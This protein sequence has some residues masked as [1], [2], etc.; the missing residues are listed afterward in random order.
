MARHVSQSEV[1]LEEIRK[2]IELD[3]KEDYIL[4]MVDDVFKK[5]REKNLP[6]D[7]CH[8]FPDG[9]TLAGIAEKKKL[10]KIESLFLEKG[11]DISKPDTNSS[12]VLKKR[13]VTTYDGKTA[14]VAK[15]THS[16]A[17][18]TSSA[19]QNE[20]TGLKSFLHGI[21]YQLKLILII[22][23]HAYELKK[24]KSNFECTVS[25]EDP[26]AGKFDDIV[27]KYRYP[28]EFNTVYIQAKHKKNPYSIVKNDLTTSSNDSPFALVP[29]FS[30]FLDLKLLNNSNTKDLFLTTNA[31]IDDTLLPMVKE[32]KRSTAAEIDTFLATISDSERGQQSTCYR[33]NWQKM[34]LDG[35]FDS[36]KE[37][38]KNCSNSNRL[39]KLLA[40]HIHGQKK[41]TQRT[42]LFK[43]NGAAII[44]DIV[45][46][47]KDKKLDK[48]YINDNFLTLNPQ[49]RQN[50]KYFRDIFEAEYKKLAKGTDVWK[51][52]KS[53]GISVTS[54]FMTDL[55]PTSNP[56]YLPNDEVTD[57]I[58]E[59]FFNVFV[60]VCNTVNEEVLTKKVVE[61]WENAIVSQLCNSKLSPTASENARSIMTEY[62]FDWISRNGGK[63]NESDIETFY[64]QLFYKIQFL[65]LQ[66]VTDNRVQELKQ[67]NIEVERQLLRERCFYHH[68][69]P[70]TKSDGVLLYSSHF[71]TSLVA[72]I[73]MQTLTIP[74]EKKDEYE[75]IF[76]D[77][78]TYQHIKPALEGIFYYLQV[79]LALIVECKN[80]TDIESSV[81]TADLV[82]GSKMML[83]DIPESFLKKMIFIEQI[84]NKQ[85]LN[86]SENFLIR[87]L[88][89]RSRE[90]FYKQHNN[91]RC[92]G[93]NVKLEDIVEHDDDL[94]YLFELTKMQSPSEN[95]IE[96]KYS[97]IQTWYIERTIK[98][99]RIAYAMKKT[100]YRTRAEMKKFSSGFLDLSSFCK[101][102]TS[103]LE[104]TNNLSMKRFDVGKI[105]DNLR[106]Q[107]A[108]GTKPECDPKKKMHIIVDEPGIGKTTYLTWLAKELQTEDSSNWIIPFT[109]IEYATDFARMCQHMGHINPTVV[110]R[111]LF[112]LLYLAWY[113]PKV[114]R[115]TI[116]ETDPVREKAKRCA[117][118]LE[119]TA[120]NQHVLI[121]EQE[122]RKLGTQQLAHL[123]IFKKKYNDSKMI[124]L[125]DGFDEIAPHYKEIVLALFSHYD[126]MSGIARIYLSSRPN[127]FET[128]FENNF[129]Q[130][131][132][133][134][135]A[136]FSER[137]QIAYLDTFLRRMFREYAT[138]QGRRDGYELLCI[139]HNVTDELLGD[140]KKIPL[141]MSVSSELLLPLVQTHISFEHVIVV[142]TDLIEEAK[143]L[144]EPQNMI[145][146]FIDRKLYILNVE[147]TGTTDAAYNIPATQ[148]NA[149]E[150]NAVK[151]RKHILLALYGMCGQEE[152]NVLLEQNEQ[153]EA[154]QYM[155]QVQLGKEKSGIVE[156]FNDNVP[157]FIHR[158]IP[159]FLMARWI[160]NNRNEGKVR[161]YLLSN[162]YWTYGKRVVRDYLN[163]MLASGSPIHQAVINQHTLEVKAII[164]KNPKA[165]STLDAGGRTPLHVASEFG[166]LLLH[167]HTIFRELFEK[168]LQSSPETVDNT[169]DLFNWRP[170]DYAM[171]SGSTQAIEMLREHGVEI[172][173]N[174]LANQ[175]L[176]SSTDLYDI[177]NRAASYEESLYTKNGRY[178]AQVVQTCRQVAQTLFTRG[179][180]NLYATIGEKNETPIELC[181]GRDAPELLK[182]LLFPNSPIKFAL[183]K[184]KVGI[185]EF[186][187]TSKHDLPTD[188]K[189]TDKGLELCIERGYTK[190]FEILFQQYRQQNNLPFD[191]NGHDEKEDV[192]EGFKHGAVFFEDCWHIHPEPLI[193]TKIC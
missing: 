4:L 138:L 119:V 77:D 64:E 5:A 179:N 142:S 180:L 47:A 89:K 20:N 102:L 163:R 169:D 107:A 124:I 104:I 81:M 135:L 105:I 30:S 164:N 32:L 167:R 83:E 132:F 99:G 19:K 109:S 39:A 49:T 63:M 42:A 172:D 44:S 23:A 9:Q 187:V 106:Q 190:L 74:Q 13:R 14:N 36:L 18:S 46:K 97:K 27:Y 130:P 191:P 161:E 45:G 12:P 59:E 115:Q 75:Y 128:D 51:D 112:E 143:I 145:E 82:E 1:Y 31:T 155:E 56:P 166:D 11:T 121:D 151:Y 93:T 84:D 48:Y 55:S 149:E 171:R 24:N 117:G 17:I 144:F 22:F 38:L 175:I 95:V 57:T 10:E 53:K 147:K 52:V 133:Y 96:Q 182:S 158:T 114:N 41:L 94:M 148:L 78:R 154:L 122:A 70:K 160:F 87:H 29:Y 2:Y 100:R 181:I 61:R 25:T 60:L 54:G 40:E 174:V 141:F 7:V 58:L 168:L 186:I 137:D 120:G 71:D 72:A 159:E 66:G 127:M 21:A 37:K 150:L 35:E 185:L 16:T 153:T 110:L 192:G 188:G 3:I 90:S 28:G 34:K 123:R 111:F 139:L 156:A 170:I 73:V 76:L 108:R 91:M 92:F 134:H 131:E 86:D 65:Q 62:A 15:N 101:E 184:S 68:L 8:K 50:V 103:Q 193:S 140:Q 116:E 80:E 88:T 79:N 98:T 165:A 67:L 183:D 85:Q 126:K 176:H 43:A 118:L 136:P 33:L 152:L 125:F 189:V 162:Q 157:Q 26:D 6:I 146:K 178:Q 173:P 177:L 113:V 129:N 69:W